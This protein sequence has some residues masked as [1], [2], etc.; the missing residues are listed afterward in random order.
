MACEIIEINKSSSLYS[1]SN[2]EE[3]N[4]ESFDRNNSKYQCCCG[5]LHSTTG[6]KIITLLL[7]VALL[8]LLIRIIINILEESNSNEQSL[9]FRCFMICPHA[10]SMTWAIWKES[11]SCMIPFITLQIVGLF[12]GCFQVIALLYIIITEPSIFQDILLIYHISTY[13]IIIIFQIWFIVIVISCWKYYCDKRHHGAKTA[14]PHFTLIQPTKEGSNFN[15]ENET[16]LHELEKLNNK[17]IPSMENV[18]SEIF[19]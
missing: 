11:P 16:N 6:V 5:L 17:T 10:L 7:D 13:T 9:I 8:F 3:I 15:K 1:L 4:I 12:I 19:I 2:V 18:D 14:Y